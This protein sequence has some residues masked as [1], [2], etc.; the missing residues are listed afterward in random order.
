MLAKAYDPKRV[1]DWSKMTIEPKHD[2]VRVLIAVNHDGSATYFSR[3]GREL[4]MFE[5][6][7]DAANVVR[8]AL[9]KK[10]GWRTGVMLDGEMV[11]LSK[12]FGD[13][14]GAIHRKDAQVR[15]AVFRCFGAL[16][17]EHFRKGACDVPQAEVNKLLNRACQEK[18]LREILFTIPFHAASDTEVREYYAMFRDD[19]HEGAMVKDLS[20]PWT[21]G[22]SYAWMKMKAEITVDVPIVDFKKGKGKY[23]EVMGALI[24]DHNG[25][26]VPVSGMDD[27]L[28]N[29]M[30]AHRKKYLGRMVEVAC[31][32]VTERGSLR[33]PR[34]VRLRPDKD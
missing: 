9:S 18:E 14:S 15:H 2:G 30:W 27:A 21:A 19:G 11:S 10:F 12:K 31:Q 5:H 22:R 4:D 6:I 25:V 33:H 17:I 20:V 3:N 29:E 1:K 28:R 8:R 34:F 24:V 7:S 26:R 13:I 32:E 16:A 23:S